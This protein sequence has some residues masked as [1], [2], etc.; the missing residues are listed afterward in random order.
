MIPQIIV[1]RF[2]ASGTS[3]GSQHLNP[4]FPRPCYGQLISHTKLLLTR[5]KY[6]HFYVKAV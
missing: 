4:F 6:L 3:I 5:E 2:R 1:H